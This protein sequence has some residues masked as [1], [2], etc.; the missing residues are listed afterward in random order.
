MNTT[1]TQYSNLLGASQH[2]MT[3]VDSKFPRASAGGGREGTEEFQSGKLT[4]L[5]S[6]GKLALCA[7]PPPNKGRMAHALSTLHKNPSRNFNL[8]FDIV[9][10]VDATGDL[11]IYYILI[12]NKRKQLILRSP[13]TTT[14]YTEYR[15][16]RKFDFGLLLRKIFWAYLF[17]KI[18]Q[19]IL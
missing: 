12:F 7:V 6:G 5:N 10:L 2:Q 19:S 17:D 3:N 18:L 8:T 16:R 11:L 9:L 13:K 4:R 1:N 15:S 14:T